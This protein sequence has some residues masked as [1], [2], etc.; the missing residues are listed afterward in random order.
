MKSLLLTV[1]ALITLP[2]LLSAGENVLFEDTFDEKLA[3]GWH[4]L[5]EDKGNWRIREGALEILVQPGKAQTVKNALVRPAP[6]RSTK[7]YAVETTVTFLKAPIQQFEQGGITWYHKKKP[8][9]K[10]VHEHIDGDEWIIPGRKPAPAQ[11][12]RLRLIV[13]G[14][15]WT[16]Q[17]SETLDGDYQTAATGPLPAPGDDQ[18]SLQCYDGPPGSDHWIRFDNF[19]I[20]E[21]AE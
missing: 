7:K 10:L 11:T 9:F 13:D 16:A 19:R 5:R 4:W 14:T 3:D 15:N 2:G 18:I 20:V 1:A 21:L 6:D 12:V 8:V 17:F